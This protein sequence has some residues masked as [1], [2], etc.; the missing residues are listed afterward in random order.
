MP[1]TAIPRK[2]ATKATKNFDFFGLKVSTNESYLTVYNGKKAFQYVIGKEF[3]TTKSNVA[4]ISE[5]IY[6]ISQF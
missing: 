6:Y 2:I 5:I 3:K 1:I 4:I